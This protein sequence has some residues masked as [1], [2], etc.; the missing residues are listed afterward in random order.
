[1]EFQVHSELY[2][3]LN[4]GIELD[5]I[6]DDENDKE[7]KDRLNNVQKKLKDKGKHIKKGISTQQMKAKGKINEIKK[8]MEQQ[9]DWASLVKQEQVVKDKEDKVNNAIMFMKDKTVAGGKGANFGKKM[10]D[11]RKPE[12]RE[13]AKNLM[14]EAR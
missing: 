3:L 5:I 8:E 11:K 2:D 10:K 12:N 14:K 6:L 7:S 13:K 1:M 9:G 4:T